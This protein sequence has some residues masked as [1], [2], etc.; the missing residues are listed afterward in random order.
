MELTNVDDSD[1]VAAFAALAQDSRL[2]IF[3]LLV[4]R[5]PEGLSAGTI[6][7]TLGIPAPTLSFHLAQLRQVGLV[8]QRRDSRS[9]IYAA[10][11]VRMNGLIA[12]LTESCCGGRPDLCAPTRKEKSS[13]DRI[14]KR[15]AV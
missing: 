14:A 8:T 11:V 5:G 9:L 13:D 15:K 3:R 6:A 10:D 4:A 7:E 12:Y 1:A 2:A